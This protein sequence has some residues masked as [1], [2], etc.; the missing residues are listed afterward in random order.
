MRVNRKALE[1]LID[2]IE[3]SV[4]F[5]FPL[6]FSS[7]FFFAGSF[8]PELFGYSSAIAGIVCLISVIA[9]QFTGKSNSK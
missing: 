9:L 4:A 7:I 8:K 6:L 3:I 1:N 2:Q 5:I